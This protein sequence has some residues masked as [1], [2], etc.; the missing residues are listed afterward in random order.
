M[1]TLNGDQR[2]NF[3]GGGMSSYS[4]TL[5]SG[6]LNIQTAAARAIDAVT[7][8]SDGLYSKL[9]FSAMRVQNV[10]E[11]F[12]LYGSINGQFAFKNLDVS[13]K[14][15]LGGMYA[16]RA[17]PEGEAYADEGFV[18]TLEARLLLPRFYERLPGQMHLIGFFDSGSVTVNKNPWTTEPNSRTLSGAGIGFNWMEYNNFSMKAYYALKVGSETA[19]SAPDKSGRFWIQLVKYFG[20]DRKVDIKP[21]EVTKD[22]PEINRAEPS[23]PTEKKNFEAENKSEPAKADVMTAT[24]VLLT[25]PKTSHAKEEKPVTAEIDSNASTD[26]WSILIGTYILDDALTTDMKQVRMAGFD[27][28]LTPSALKKTSMKRLYLSE[29]AYRSDALTA[30][31]KLKRKASGA[32]ILG[33]GGKFKVCAGSFLSDEYVASEMKRLSAAGFKL[34]LKL[35]EIEME[36]RSL[37]LGPF[38]DKQT[39]YEAVAKLKGFGVN[40]SL[41]GK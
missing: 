5:S 39:A 22:A 20:Y 29:F 16:V 18:G 2:D 23:K 8:R 33:E 31:E 9:G 4:F 24:S 38:R 19:K 26:V 35:V 40:A 11:S 15:E 41:L 1:G 30:L 36:S 12:S 13:E 21:V 17:Y 27:P 14:M 32:F 28:V 7:A 25:T 3:G 34:S 10:T 37:T 6:N